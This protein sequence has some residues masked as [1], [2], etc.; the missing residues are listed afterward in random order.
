MAGSIS[1]TQIIAADGFLKN[2][3][4]GVNSALPTAVAAYQNGSLVSSYGA[5]IAALKGASIA[6][7]WMPAFL[8]NLDSSGASITSNVT[9]RATTIASNTKVLISNF[10]AA[11]NFCNESFDWYAVATDV[12]DNTF[13][14]YGLHIDS[15]SDLVASGLNKNFVGVQAS[16]TADFATLATIL[17]N[18]GTLYSIGNSG[19]LIGLTVKNLLSGLQNAGLGNIGG[20][21][22]QINAYRIANPRTLTVPDH[23]L[24]QFMQSITSASDIQK[25][26]AQTGIVVPP[27]SVFRSLADFLDET[28][29][30]TAD[31]VK[32]LPGGKL[33]GLNNAL[34]NMGGRFANYSEVADLLASM[35]LPNLS[36]LDTY[37]SPL[38]AATF[39]TFKANLGSGVGVY[40]NP[41][42]NDVIGTAAGFNH[43]TSFNTIANAQPT[44][45][46]SSLGQAL[47]A[48][49]DALAADPT[50]G[51]KLTTFVS[52]QSALLSTGE[53]YLVT[54]LTSCNTAMSTTQIQLA[55]EIVNCSVGGIDITANI[56]PSR[57]EL[58]SMASQLH[59]IGEDRNQLGLGTFLTAC[60]TNDAVGDAVEGAIYEGQHI[61]DTTQRGIVNMTR[62]SSTDALAKFNAR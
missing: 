23:L 62:I 33:T 45:V 38:P 58:L 30:M 7:P 11:S 1:P 28:R 21:Q 17:R 14:D 44:L 9:N 32:A 60:S 35:A 10:S 50:N 39:A 34:I 36:N 48:A 13:G 41:T 24:L 52:A 40:S 5:M 37:T 19:T 59:T 3:G 26:I 8:S 55:R 18:L 29:I 57:N 2:Q 20:L 61:K 25:V 53:G 42:V 46:A 31:Q 54:L 4:L 22:D 12:S 49:A 27:T 43:I 15:Y 56:V 47:K 6:L 51:T 16:P